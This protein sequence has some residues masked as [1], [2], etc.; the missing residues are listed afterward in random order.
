[1]EKLKLRKD[2]MESDLMKF[3]KSEKMNKQWLFDCIDSCFKNKEKYNQ[4]IQTI[5]EFAKKWKEEKIEHERMWLQNQ[6]HEQKRRRELDEINDEP[7][8]CNY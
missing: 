4:D 1:M 8:G 2:L 3:I 7:R 6:E 5:L